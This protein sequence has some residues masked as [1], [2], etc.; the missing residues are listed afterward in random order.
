MVQRKAAYVIYNQP[1]RK[2]Q[3]DSVSNMLEKLQWESLES[4]HTKVDITMLK[5]LNHLIAIPQ[6]YHPVA[7]TRNMKANHS[8]KLKHTRAKR[9]IYMNSIFPR[10]FP[11]PRAIPIWNQQP[12]KLIAQGTLDGFKSVHSTMTY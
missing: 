12:A 11:R 10:P 1:Y 4:R 5:T 6:Q 7:G 9:N 2:N 3:S 8:Y